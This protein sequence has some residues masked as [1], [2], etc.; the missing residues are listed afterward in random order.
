MYTWPVAQISS[1]LIHDRFP[2][3]LNGILTSFFVL[4]GSLT[5]L[6]S[7]I[8]IYSPFLSGEI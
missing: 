8:G 4:V 6:I 3:L 2:L 1:I 7:L 5:G